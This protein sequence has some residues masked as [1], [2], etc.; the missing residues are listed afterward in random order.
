MS[1]LEQFRKETRAWLE[2]NCPPEMRKPVRSEADICWVPSVKGGGTNAALEAMKRAG[3]TPSPD[4]AW[5]HFVHVWDRA[6]RA[7][8]Q[9]RQHPGGQLDRTERD[10]LLRRFSARIAETPA[11]ARLLVRLGTGPVRSHALGAEALTIGSAAEATV[12]LAPAPGVPP[13]LAAL[14]WEQGS[15]LLENRRSGRRQV[16]PNGTRLNIE[17]TPL[18]IQVQIG[19][20]CNHPASIS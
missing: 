15:V 2:A 17:G 18:E 7:N 9:D 6:M 10:A 5:C 20:A 4:A 11:H 1:D 8:R 12:R 16:L 14:R 3:L 13:I 19:P